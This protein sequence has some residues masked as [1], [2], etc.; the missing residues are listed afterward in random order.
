MRYK[1]SVLISLLFL[2][3]AAAS[4]H[5]QILLRPGDSVTV[6]FDQPRLLERGKPPALLRG[7]SAQA[8]FA[9]D[10]T[11]A[12]LTATLQ[13]RS[14]A[15]SAAALY[16]LDFGLSLK[17]V[18]RTKM[19]ASFSGFPE[20][21]SWAGPVDTG[22]TTAGTGY[23]TFA[24]RDAILGSPGDFL[25]PRTLLPSGFLS[26]GQSRSITLEFE[27]QPDTKESPLRI[28]PT[29]FF[30]APNPDAPQEKRLRLSAFGKELRN[31]KAP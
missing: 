18:N 27:F 1:L 31:Q 20:G 16:A 26:S 13:N 17:V 19:S 28:A 21:A 22:S 29:V 12:R 6:S 15:A 9:L 23:S 5:A 14:L 4:I 10:E 24:A 8:T 30:L 25:N 2:L 11:G 3:G 7:I